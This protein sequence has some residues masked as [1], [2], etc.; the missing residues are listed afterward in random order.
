MSPAYTE[1]DFEDHA[2]AQLLASGY[3]QRA[4]EDYDKELCLIPDE[5]IKDAGYL[6]HRNTKIEL[7]TLR[8]FRCNKIRS[9]T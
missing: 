8:G 5:V 9:F 7:S 1:K 2:E 3:H 6:I 4:P